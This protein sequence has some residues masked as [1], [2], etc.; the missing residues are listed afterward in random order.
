M[1]MNLI[2]FHK[3]DFRYP[4]ADGAYLAG[5][6]LDRVSVSITRGEYVALLGD[7]G[8]GK[9][10][11]LKLCNALLVPD[12]GEVWVGGMDSRSEARLIEIR[13]GAGMV[14]HDP[15]SQ[16][17]GTT[18]AEDV[19]F[20][21]ENLGLP[22]QM[23]R[24]RVQ[25]A[26]QALSLTEQ[27][28]APVHL[29]SGWH[30]LKLALAGVLAM[31]PDCLLVDDASAMLNGAERKE[32]L[33]LLRALSRE[34]GIAVLQA[35]GDFEVAAAADRIVLLKE[36]RI[37][38]DVLQ[39]RAAPPIPIEEAAVPRPQPSETVPDERA[40]DEKESNWRALLAGR[41]LAGSS[42]LHRCDPRTKFILAL[43]LLAAACTLA[44]P[45]A[46]ALLLAIVLASGKA[47][48]RPL[49]H[50]LGSLRPV[51]C[52]ALLTGAVNLVDAGGRGLAE[53]G[54]LSHISREGGLF[55]TLMAL[56]LLLMAATA[57][58]L[59]C[60]T[61]PCSLAD[62]I[63]KVLRPLGRV[64]FPVSQLAALLQVSLRL[65]P[66]IVEEAEKLIRERSPGGDTPR[67]GFL[68]RLASLPPLLIPL[69]GK[70]ARRGEAMA[71]AMEARCYQGPAGR[72]RMT[73][74]SFSGADLAGATLLLVVLAAA[75]GV[76]CL[77]R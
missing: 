13:R 56:R 48:G 72:S 14:F 75:V 28:G 58:L 31:Q 64:G 27:A 70:V 37:T 7:S 66:V 9:T 61:T 60:T 22:P 41:Y 54:A 45:A 43:L 67:E 8:S 44:T 36:G 23:V 49:R 3:V 39:T 59:T 20:G 69:F 38:L 73:P 74:L 35:T 47:C 6:V 34:R 26:L 10:T 68:R 62:G 16:I 42:P 25:D 11:F 33:R 57:S 63:E 76:E 52:L 2:E 29:L 24:A 12:R 5:S 53:H 51:L 77:Q 30:K 15:D 1:G 32:L 46:L 18:V 65:L 21:P 71:E 55:V 17:I 40:G 4:N 50:S 19:A